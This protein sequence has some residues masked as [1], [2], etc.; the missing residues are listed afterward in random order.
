MITVAATRRHVERERGGD[1]LAGVFS[2]TW[3]NNGKS[4]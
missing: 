3:Y 4:L 1:E 2:L